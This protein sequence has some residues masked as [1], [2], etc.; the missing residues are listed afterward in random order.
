MLFNR[1]TYKCLLGLA[2]IFSL[3]TSGVYNNQSIGSSSPI[4]LVFEQ[5][6]QIN[7]FYLTF[8]KSVTTHSS[9]SEFH[10]N[11]LLQAQNLFSIY[12][13]QIQ[14]NYYL[15]CVTNHQLEYITLLS[16]SMSL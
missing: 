8:N 2:L 1:Q 16:F 5:K 9:F 14:T 6:P 12:Q 15:N 4:E 13:Q 3:G 11:T 7:A 10:F